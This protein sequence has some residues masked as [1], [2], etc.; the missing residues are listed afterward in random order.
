MTDLNQLQ[1]LKLTYCG[2]SARVIGTNKVVYG[3]RFPPV[4]R[5]TTIPVFTSSSTEE[6]LRPDSHIDQDTFINF[7]QSNDTRQVNGKWKGGA[8]GINNFTCT[9][10]VWFNNMY[11]GDVFP[12]QIV[13]NGVAKFSPQPF[14]PSQQLISQDTALS[15]NGVWNNNTYAFY[16]TNE[17]MPQKA[18]DKLWAWGNNNQL[19]IKI[20]RRGSGDNVDCPNR[21]IPAAGE[22]IEPGQSN[23]ARAQA[24]FAFNEEIGVP[25]TTLS[26]CY[27]IP[28]GTYND[29]GRDP[30]YWSYSMRQNNEIVSCGIERES[31]SVAHVIYIETT[32]DIEPE[33]TEQRDKVEIQ[34]KWWED[35][36]TVLQSHDESEWMLED[37]MKFVPDTIKAIKDFRLLS[38]DEKLQYKF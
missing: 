19:N 34:S 6:E 16:M 2:F 26:K 1:I 10:K 11:V 37:H 30:R 4:I 29:E 23:E 14:D 32:D 13:H 33:E 15:C 31:S 22:H 7:I 24:L 12:F 36:H 38:E 5:S 20:L 35:I 21:I 28:L 25:K 8:W 17:P 18:S 9:S 3:A 27:I